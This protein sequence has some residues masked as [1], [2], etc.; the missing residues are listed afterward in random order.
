MYG[1]N[2]GN[3]HTGIGVE[4]PKTLL[5]LPRARVDQATRLRLS[6]HEGFGYLLAQLLIQLKSPQAYQPID[7]HRLEGIVVDLVS[8]LIAHATDAGHTL[9]AESRQ[10]VLAMHIRAFVKQHLHDPHLTLGAIA[11]AHHISL[12]YLHRLFS[13]QGESITALIRRQ[14]LGRVPGATWPTPH[15]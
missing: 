13:E 7:G 1:G 5:S 15:N 9:P 14:R 2:D 10:R 4:V 3:P 11:S 6:A 12:S 8:A